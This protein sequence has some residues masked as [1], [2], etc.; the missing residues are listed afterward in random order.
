[1]QLQE[2]PV[3]AGF[4]CSQDS[5]TAFR[6]GYFAGVGV[7]PIERRTAAR[8]SADVVIPRR[9]ASLSISAILSGSIRTIIRA[10]FA[11]FS[12]TIVHRHFW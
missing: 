2:D 11:V 9:A 1:M 7:L 8:I 12:S 3:R 10:V 4:F 6:R 5:D